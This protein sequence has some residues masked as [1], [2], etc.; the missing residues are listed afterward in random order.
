MSEIGVAST[1]YGDLSGTISV[2]GHDGPFLAA[3]AA[4]SDMPA[5]YH[6]VGLKLYTGCPADPGAARVYLLAVEW[7]AVEAGGGSVAAYAAGAEAVPVF[8]FP[9]NATAADVLRLCKVV[10][11]VLG[12]KVLAG[13]TLKILDD[14]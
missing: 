7:D 8:K 13:K 1:Q 11:V 10:D 12:D 5:G 4:R 2:D 6:P 3:L 14:N 9:V